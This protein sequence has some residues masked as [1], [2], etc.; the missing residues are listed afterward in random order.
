MNSSVQSPAKCHTR[1]EE[2]MFAGILSQHLPREMTPE[3]MEAWR[4]DP[5]GLASVLAGLKHAP[6]PSR[7]IGFHRK[8]GGVTKGVPLAREFRTAKESPS[9][10]D[11]AGWPNSAL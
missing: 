3:D 2:L 4:N 9:D 11:E 7:T 10:H 5:E 1:H 6:K 8:D